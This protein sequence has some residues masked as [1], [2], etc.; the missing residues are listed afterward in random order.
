MLECGLIF[1]QRVFKDNRFATLG[2]IKSK[3]I[4]LLHS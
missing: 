1:T 2:F 3:K 4:K